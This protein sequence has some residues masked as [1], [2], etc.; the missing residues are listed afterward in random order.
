MNQSLE[1]ILCEL[2][3]LSNPEVIKAKAQKF[4][5]IA[6]NA[7]GVY[8]KD[9]QQ[10]AKQI[11]LN[12]TLAVQLFDTG[13]YEARLLCSKIYHPKDITEAQMDAWVRTFENWEIC[14]SFCMGLFS[15]S[16]FALS[17]ALEWSNNDAEFVKRAAF[18]LMASYGFA[19][20]KAENT[21]FQQFL[22]IIMHEAHDERKYVSK[23]INWALRNI[24]KRNAVLRLES[25]NTAKQLLKTENKAAIW[26]AKDALRELENANAAILNY[27]KSLYGGRKRG[28]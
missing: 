18:V 26:V 27:P 2:N 15:K 20:K 10:L 5:I 25:I 17:K 9:L 13:I 16:E 8:Q 21:V 28:Q 11:G 14:D 24:G 4:G 22:P 19:N 7:L 23:A 12:N 3:R 1:Q 6:S